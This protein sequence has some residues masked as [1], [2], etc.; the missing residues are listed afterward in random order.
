MSTKRQ[1]S[2]WEWFDMAPNPRFKGD[3]YSPNRD[4]TRLKKQFDRV[5]H[6]MSD[7]RWHTIAEVSEITQ[8]PPQSVAR[9]IRYIRSKKEGLK[10]EKR[11]DGNGLYAFRVDDGLPF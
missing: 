1:L 4:G 9:Q 7:R 3:D 8:D 6:V 11:Y 5:F 2:L 10:V